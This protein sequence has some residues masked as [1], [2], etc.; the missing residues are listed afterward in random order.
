M[1]AYIVGTCAKGIVY[2]RSDSV[3]KGCSA[4]RLSGLLLHEPEPLDR[5]LGGPN[6]DDVPLDRER[7]GAADPELLLDRAGR[8]GD[9]VLNLEAQRRGLDDVDADL[10]PLERARRSAPGAAGSR[11]QVLFDAGADPRPRLPL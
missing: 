11:P 1:I 3:V 7:D 2:R 4:G 8:D 5:S 10:R 9:R 6:V